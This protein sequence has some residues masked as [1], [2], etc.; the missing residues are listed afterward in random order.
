MADPLDVLHEPVVPV[1]P[2]PAF[3]TELRGRLE[4]A[5]KNPRGAAMTSPANATDTPA[6]ETAH[7]SAPPALVPYLGVH[8]ARR[9]MDWYVEVFDAQRRGEPYVNP[10][11]SIGHA[12]L[13]IRG[14]LL[15]LAEYGPP[16]P[17]SGQAATGPAHQIVV[18]VPDADTVVDRAVARG[19]DLERPVADQPYGRTGVFA[20]PYGHR[21]M[22]TA[23]SASDIRS[24]PGE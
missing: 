5:L 12:E 18:H 9:A 4:R 10:D 13:N 24:E 15:Y 19:A 8:D 14:A 22:V 20:D 23:V 2:D 1:D 16:P 17:A 21:W 11:G 7:R 3:A 6:A